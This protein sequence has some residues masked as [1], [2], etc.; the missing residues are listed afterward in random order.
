MATDRSARL[1]TASSM[2]RVTTDRRGT[3]ASA[4][5]F[6]PK[7]IDRVS[8]SRA[9]GLE[10]PF[11]AGGPDE[12]LELLQR[13]DRGQLLARLDPEPAHG[14][15]RGAVQHRDQGA[16]HP[17]EHEHRGG[18]G[19]GGGLGARD[20]HRLRYQLAHHHRG[21]GRQHQ[22]HD[23]RR[24]RRPSLAHHRLGQGFEGGGDRRLGDEA[25]HEGRDGDA[26]LGAR[27]VERQ[28]PQGGPRR[29]GA[30]RPR[31]RVDLD[32][33]A[34]DGDQRELDRDEEPGGQDEQ[35][36]GQEAEGGLDGG[37]PGRG[38]GLANLR[39]TARVPGHAARTRGAPRGAPHRGGP[40][41][42]RQPRQHRAPAHRR[43]G[44]GRRPPLRARA[45]GGHRRRDGRRLR[46]GLR[47]TRLLQP[48]HV[49]RPRQR[50]R[51]PHQRQGQPLAAGRD[52][53]AAG[54]PPHRDRSAPVG[55]A[56]RP[57]RR[58]GEVGARGPHHRR[59]GHDPA[60]C[61]PR[62]RPGPRRAR[63]RVAAR[64]TCST[65]RPAPTLPPRR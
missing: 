2:E 33:I 64:W 29:P 34:I 58:R 30:L 22:G 7:R 53:R 46:P 37:R 45:A 20:G 49:G 19:V 21:D 10:R 16:E 11:L 8:R 59:A 42:L 14:P 18:E 60:P 50:H 39:A 15:V 26:E 44:R 55:P 4:A 31:P 52:R 57:R 36:Y 54:L 41:P 1:D 23:D 24:A 61:V 5:S 35:E 56:R 51:Q 65:P 38:A 32:T 13:A 43:P 6:T 47:A 9:S 3:R 63:L 28:P 40:P 62:Q 48:P 12:Q 27:E 17:G 25:D